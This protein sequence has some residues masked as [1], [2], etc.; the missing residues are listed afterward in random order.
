MILFWVPKNENRLKVE[1]TRDAQVQLLPI[2]L[3]EKKLYFN[4]V[5]AHKYPG[6]FKRKLS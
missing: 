6:K 1:P 3:L 2:S 4:Q 5:F